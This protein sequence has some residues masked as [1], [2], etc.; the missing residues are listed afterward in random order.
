MRLVKPEI[1]SL[2]ART[3]PPSVPR[4]DLRPPDE[5][6]RMMEV[7]GGYDLTGAPL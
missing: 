1:E 7:S 2:F 6:A 3:L 4:L 5:H